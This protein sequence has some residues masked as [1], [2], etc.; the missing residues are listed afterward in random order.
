MGILTRERRLIGSLVALL[1]VVGCHRPPDP[2]PVD[3][4]DHRAEV[5]A[6]HERRVAEMAAPDSWLSLIGL[7]W[8][9]EGETT[10]GSAPDNDIVLPEKAAPRVGR[11]IL[12]THAV[13]QNRSPGKRARRVDGHHSDA[14]S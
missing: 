3:E 7:H 9:R 2:L 10:V 12:H 1:L 4:A 13:S 14:P 11:V 6:W 5:A 8:L